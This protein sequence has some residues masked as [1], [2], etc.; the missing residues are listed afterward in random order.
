MKYIAIRTPQN[1]GEDYFYDYFVVDE[2]FVLDK[3]KFEK[4]FH[5]VYEN[6]IELNKISNDIKFA[7]KY[8]TEIMELIDHKDEMTQSDLQGAVM[9]IVVK[10]LVERDGI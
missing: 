5:E 4:R 9:C 10:M 8:T 6:T 1:Y 3:E 2:N 7:N